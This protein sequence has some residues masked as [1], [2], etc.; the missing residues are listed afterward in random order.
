MGV[1]RGGGMTGARSFLAV[2][3][4]Q[5]VLT[6]RLNFRT[7]LAVIYGYLL[8]IVFLFAFAGIFRT[9]RPPLLAEIGQLLTITILGS[10]A[11]GLPTALVADR[12]RGVWRRCRLLPVSPA[13]LVG[14]ALVARFVI[15]AGAVALQL[16]LAHAVFG[17]PWPANPAVFAASLLASTF[18]FLGLGLLIAALADGVPAVQALGQCVFLP[19]ILLGGVGVP[20][21][22]LPGW[23]QRLAG[24]MPGRYAVTALQHGFETARGPIG[25]GFALAALTVVGG[26]ATVIGLLLF[27]WDNS[28][29]A[30]RRELLGTG[31]A[32]LAWLGVGLCAAG[33]GRLQP[34]LPPGHEWREI[35]DAQIAAITYENLPGDDE[36]VTRFAR[37]LARPLVS[38]RLLTISERLP[39]WTAANSDNPGEAIRCL[40][41]L[42]TIADLAQDPQEGEIARLVFDHLRATFPEPE[43]RRGLAWV[44][45][46]PDDGTAPTNAP[47]LGFRRELA[48]D[49]VRNR[50]PLYAQKFLGRLT[51]QLRER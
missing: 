18:A 20:I 22:V 21:A 25:L 6:L 27:R 16:T 51:G 33:T 10:A 11:L 47:A 38:A 14:G 26:A 42:A 5:A 23:A 29:R 41:S 37:P 9:G 36:L 2:L 1:L 50:A 32:L 30:S 15:V 28:A 48:E 43:L 7:P 31:A 24:F 45:L 4:R 46:R 3:R 12:E 13:A 44:V 35:T 34:T 39:A 8:P 49:A 17:T 40:V 19:M